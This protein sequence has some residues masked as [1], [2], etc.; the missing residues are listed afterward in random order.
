MNRIR[1]GIVGTG[2]AARDLHLPGLKELKDKFEIVAL[3]NKTKEKAIQF[4]KLVDND[5][6]ICDTYEELLENV[7]AVD[8]ALPVQF[9]YEFIEK[10]LKKGVNVICEKPISINV[11]EGKKIVEITKNYESI[12]YIAENYRHFSAFDKIKELTTK[13]G[14]IYYL[15]WNLW[16]YMTKENKYANTKWR[17]NPEHIGGFI[18]DAGVHHVASMRKIFGDIKWVYGT[19]KNIADYLGGP[20]LLSSTF[21]FENGVLGNYNVSYA[22][23]GKN[24]LMIKGEFG[25]IIFEDD[26]IKVVNYRNKTIHYYDEYK[27]HDEDSYKKEFEDFYEVINGKENDLGNV[28]EALKDLAFIEASIKSNGEKRIYIND[29]IK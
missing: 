21:E 27:T 12:V 11:E 15:Q 23:D 4:S 8:L 13:I 17:Q 26:I 20:D 1:L 29:L 7:D 2:I 10:A 18:S 25:D 5:P 22:L 19:V 6:I 24:R 9:N 16:I 3:F 28:E 14:K